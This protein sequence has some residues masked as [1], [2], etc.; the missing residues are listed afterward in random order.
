MKLV[1]RRIIRYQRLSTQT[2]THERASSGNKKP[3]Q[4]IGFFSQVTF[5][6]TGSYTAALAS[7]EG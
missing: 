3:V 2:H 7:L 6:S 1:G 5:F 4:P